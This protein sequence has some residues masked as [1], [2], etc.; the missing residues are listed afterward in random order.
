[1]ESLENSRFVDDAE[2]KDLAKCYS[3]L[4]SG[5]SVGLERSMTEVVLCGDV[6]PYD[7]AMLCIRPHPWDK[8]SGAEWVQKAYPKYLNRYR[9]LGYASL[10]AVI[11][12]KNRKGVVLLNAWMDMA[13]EIYQIL[14]SKE[15]S[16]F[17]QCRVSSGK[18]KVDDFLGKT[19]VSVMPA[20]LKFH[21][22]DRQVANNNMKEAVPP[23]FRLLIDAMNVIVGEERPR[24]WQ[25]FIEIYAMFFF[26]AAA[27]SLKNPEEFEKANNKFLVTNKA[28]NFLAANNGLIFLLKLWPH[29]SK[30]EQWVGENEGAYRDFIGGGNE[31]EEIWENFGRRISRYYGGAVQYVSKTEKMV[32]DLDHH[33]SK[34]DE[35]QNLD[36]KADYLSKLLLN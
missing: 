15:V 25:S 1:M 8:E 10:L 23:L 4:N 20:Y 12:A 24:T 17:E 28:V 27:S 5:T 33:C 35:A 9:A 2:A 34:T 6:L 14:F 30:D 11:N 26:R 36:F 29:L 18:S 22:K 31:G 21:E 32:T 3:K 7:T 16:G 19:I 13:A